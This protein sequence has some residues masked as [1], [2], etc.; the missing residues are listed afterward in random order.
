M[1]S[2]EERVGLRVLIR[3]GWETATAATPRPV[4]SRGYMLLLA[5]GA[6]QHQQPH[7]IL[8]GAGGGVTC[9]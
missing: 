7:L 1:S 8:G 5:R 4:E 9:S 2:C 3:E 6:R